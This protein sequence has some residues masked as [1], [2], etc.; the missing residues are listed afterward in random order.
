M[1]VQINIFISL[2]KFQ[3]LFNNITCAIF[4]YFSSSEIVIMNMS[5]C[6]ILPHMRLK[7]SSFFFNFLFLFLKL[8]NHNWSIFKFDNA[9]FC[10]HKYVLYSHYQIFPF[11]YFKSRI[12]L[13]SL[14]TF[15][16]TFLIPL[17]D[18]TLFS[19]FT[20][21]HRFLSSVNR[22]KIAG[23][24]SLSSKSNIWIFSGLVSIGCLLT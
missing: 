2:I 21:W 10:Y 23:W 11:R 7:L 16:I 15:S 13:M 18:E 5:V 4:L 9:F 20:Y 22:F 19:Y 1:H 14:F 8:D 12:S 3:P 17:F 6:L 24:K